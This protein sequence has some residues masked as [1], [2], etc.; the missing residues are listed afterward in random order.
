V[1]EN[2]LS[3]SGYTH[4]KP[5]PFG[6][7]YLSP[8]VLPCFCKHHPKWVRLAMVRLRIFFPSCHAS[9]SRMA[10]G[11]LRL[12]MHSINMEK[13]LFCYSPSVKDLLN[14][15]S[16][17]R[18]PDVT[19]RTFQEYF[20]KALSQITLALNYLIFSMFKSLVLF[21]EP[22]NVDYSVKMLISF[23]ISS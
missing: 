19:I 5:P 17:K 9:R 21:Q 22:T 2:T 8:F 13:Y 3:P 20:T 15:L 4:G 11:E 14:S 12:G 10:G 23:L 7:R 18:K 16:Y 1:I 6:Q